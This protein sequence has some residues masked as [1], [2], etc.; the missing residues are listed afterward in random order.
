MSLVEKRLALGAQDRLL[1]N[2][3]FEQEV[4][5]W[6]LR[7]RCADCIHFSPGSKTCSLKYPNHMLLDPAVIALYHDNQFVFCKDFEMVCS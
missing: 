3:Q 2:A 1:C 5:R 7:Y 6:S 4:Q